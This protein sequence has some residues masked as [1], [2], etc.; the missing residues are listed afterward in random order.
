MSG[1]FTQRRGLVGL[2]TAKQPAA[3]GST[4]PVRLCDTRRGGEWTIVRVGWEDCGEVQRLCEMG[5]TTGCVLQVLGRRGE[6]DPVRVQIGESRLCLD[7]DV[8]SHFLVT[9][10]TA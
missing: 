7:H 4:E 2:L 3:S 8:A 1:L 9:A 5:L 6:G 10:H